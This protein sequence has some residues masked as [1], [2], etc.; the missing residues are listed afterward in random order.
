MN[1]RRKA[2]QILTLAGVLLA[3]WLAAARLLPRLRARSPSSRLPAG[4]PTPVDEEERR[5]FPTD[6]PLELEIEAIQRSQDG[7]GILVCTLSTPWA[8]A[9]PYPDTP[10]DYLYQGA[11]SQVHPT[12]V[13]F[14]IRRPMAA[15]FVG[16]GESVTQCCI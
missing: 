15:P 10:V 11:F 3:A 5:M 9:D 2:V 8:A 13:L 4:P 16:A 14:C 6:K 12:C 7:S 1:R